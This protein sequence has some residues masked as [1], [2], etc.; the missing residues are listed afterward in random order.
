MP[1]GKI[2][3]GVCP[4]CGQ[5]TRAAEEGAWGHEQED[6]PHESPFDCIAALHSR[7]SHVETTLYTDPDD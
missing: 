2:P 5:I 7:L 3:R 1:S 6:L 4:H